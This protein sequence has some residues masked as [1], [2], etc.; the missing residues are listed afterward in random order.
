MLRFGLLF[1]LVACHDTTAPTP[2]R[3]V[4]AAVALAGR[5]TVG[6]VYVSPIRGLRCQP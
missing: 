6:I 1:F 5:D 4:V 2:L 3:C